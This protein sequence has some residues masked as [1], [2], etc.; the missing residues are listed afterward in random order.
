V[1]A[2]SIVSAQG[3]VFALVDA[4]G[5][6]NGKQAQKVLHRLLEDEDAMALWGMVIRQFRLLL[7]AK[8]ILD[9]GG[10]RTTVQQ[11]FGVPE[12]VAGKISE[13]SR[14][15]SLSAL[16]KIHHRLLEMD[17]AAKTG[18]MPLDAALDVFVVGM[19]RSMGL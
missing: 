2:V 6:G 3:D 7:Q 9:G 1:E 13:Q 4:L 12:F 11:T 14:R 17:E 18:V 5:S 8:E 10:N 15:F 19:S 16:E